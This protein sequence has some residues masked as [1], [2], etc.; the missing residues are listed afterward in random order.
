MSQIEAC[1][2]S[3]KPAVLVFGEVLFDLIKQH[4]QDASIEAKVVPGGAPANF[5]FRLKSRQQDADNFSLSLVSAIGFDPLGT[6][7]LDFLEAKGFSLNLIQ[8]VRE[9]RTGTVDVTTYQ[10]GRSADYI[11][12]PA[13]YDNI[14]LK[15]E[16]SH[17]ASKSK[18][19]YFG[20]LI[21]RDQNGSAETL[22]K[23]LPSLPEEAIKF[24]DV[25]L[26]NNCYT[27]ESILWSANNSDI[28]KLNHEEVKE[29]AAAV[30]VEGGS[31]KEFALAYA[32]TNKKIA[33][34]TLA[35]KGALIA[36]PEQGQVML[37]YVAGYQLS[38]EQI[39]DTVGCGDSFGAEFARLY[40]LKFPIPKCLELANE[41]GAAVALT[42]GGM[43]LVEPRHLE[44]VRS[45]GRNVAPGF[46]PALSP[47]PSA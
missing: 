31:P 36:Y 28:L 45:A 16:I 7:I 12:H 1:V 3:Q 26:R 43:A 14:S 44:I 17:V 30:G 34:V 5:A 39:K 6:K 32:E 33:I 29:V 18:L 21:Q 37:S 47:S 23:I 25:N 35:E 46:G 22:R 10:D 40:M 42:E 13:A 20:S 11:I 41:I 38:K 24:V 27:P 8:R 9:H 15:S 19:I 4:G 2:T